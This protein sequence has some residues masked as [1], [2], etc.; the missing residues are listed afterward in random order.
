MRN[1]P[2]AWSL[3]TAWQVKAMLETTKQKINR[4]LPPTLLEKLDKLGLTVVDQQDLQITLE[5]YAAARN[6]NRMLRAKL[7]RAMKGEMNTR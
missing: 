5:T 1:G 3:T 4:H 7:A 2:L 6:E